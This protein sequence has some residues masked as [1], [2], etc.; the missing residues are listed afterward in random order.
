MGKWE[1][2]AVRYEIARDAQESLT[3]FRL[4][5]LKPQSAENAIKELRE[6]VDEN[7]TPE[8]QTCFLFRP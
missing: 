7:Q 6:G 3:M 5:K 8:I 2:K 1:I 4:G